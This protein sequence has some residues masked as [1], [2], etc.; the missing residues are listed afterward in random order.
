MDLL[1]GAL[2]GGMSLLGGLFAQDKTDE[3][4]QE[5]NRFNAEQ[6]QKQMD[7]Q[8]RMSNSA[9][10]RTMQDMR[11]AGLNPI[12]AYS[13]GGASTPSG[14]A[15]SGAYS[16][17]NDIVTPAVSSA[18]QSMRVKQEVLNMVEQNKNLLEQNLNLQEQRKQIGSQIANIN[19]DTLLKGQ[20][21]TIGQKDVERSKTDAKIYQSSWFPILRALG[22]GAREIGLGGEVGST[23]TRI[24]VHPGSYTGER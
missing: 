14:A 6:A 4:M 21:L 5:T 8:E 1:T 9:Y 24:R 23:G 10:Q 12:L 22:T 11:A 20:L 2:T 16:A 7:F 19:A 13:K 15:G 3:R 17:A 18:V